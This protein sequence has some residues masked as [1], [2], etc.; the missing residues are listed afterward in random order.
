MITKLSVSKLAVKKSVELKL[1]SPITYKKHLNQTVNKAS[2]GSTDQTSTLQIMI[3][4]H[5]QLNH[6]LALLKQEQP[7]SMKA[8]VHHQNTDTENRF[9]SLP[10]TSC[11]SSC[12]HSNTQIRMAACSPASKSISLHKSMPSKAQ[13]T[14]Y[15]RSIISAALM[16]LGTSH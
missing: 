14:V 8:R 12:L 2:D 16:K 6:F 10:C 3:S 4:L 1:L 9:C 7:K 11:S 15:S 13:A 5:R